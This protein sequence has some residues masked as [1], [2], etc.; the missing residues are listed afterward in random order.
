MKVA[1]PISDSDKHLL[2]P[3]LDI[4]CHFG[5]LANHSVTLAPAFSQREAA[6]VAADR[7]RQVC[8]NVDV[9][10][11]EFEGDGTWPNSPNKHWAMTMQAIHA[12]GNKEP[13]FWMELDCTPIDSNWADALDNEWRRGRKAH[14]GLVLPKPSVGP[15]KVLFYEADDLFLMGC[16]IY[17]PRMLDNPMIRPMF[18]NLLTGAHSEAWDFY[19]RGHLRKDGWHHTDLICDRW[20][21]ENYRYEGPKLVCDPRKTDVVHQDYA[22]ADCSKAVLI[23]GCKDSSLARLILSGAKPDL[24]AQ[25]VAFQYAPHTSPSPGKEAQ[26]NPIKPQAEQ[27]F[28][29]TSFPKWEETL[30]EMRAASAEMKETT[31]FLKTLIEGFQQEAAKHQDTTPQT[32]QNVTLPALET[33][34]GILA[35]GKAQ[36]VALLAKELNVDKKALETMIKTDTHL[37]L[38]HGWVSLLAA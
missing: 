31:T 32:E 24:A 11:L 16:S 33:L 14:C 10:D 27:H 19:L 9:L 8:D 15:N 23:H 12:K 38:R 4:L 7:L 29:P 30:T 21:T 22:N 6:Q 25:G 2:E 36:Q 20:N 5:K 1:L 18:Q 26:W 3:L 28:P 35:D 37:H 13:V 17:N 34:R